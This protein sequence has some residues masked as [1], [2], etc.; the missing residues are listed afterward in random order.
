MNFIQNRKHKEFYFDLNTFEMLLCENI[1]VN[2]YKYLR[3]F[4]ISPVICLYDTL[5]DWKKIT[6]L[7][8]NYLQILIKLSYNWSLGTKLR[9]F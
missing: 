4:K 8:Q 6:I 7:L 5:S 3:L 1:R 2:R 9:K